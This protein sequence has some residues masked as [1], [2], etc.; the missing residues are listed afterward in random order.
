[1]IASE[2]SIPLL[3]PPDV[4]FSQ[5]GANVA[6]S[7]GSFQ[8]YFMH[9]QANTC[10]YIYFSSFFS[11]FTLWQLAFFTS[12]RWFPMST[13][14]IPPP[15]YCCAVVHC[16]DVP[17]ILKPVLY[18]L[19]F[20]N[21]SQSFV[22]TKDAAMN[23]HV[24]TRPVAHCIKQQNVLASPDFLNYFYYKVHLRLWKLKIRLEC[25]ILRGFKQL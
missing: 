24:C 20:S 17:N 1:M 3:S 2:V 14:T 21:C 6:A 8:T 18:W 22:P 15:F 23:N 4:W 7:C 19:D 13:D 12:W 11:F 25:L 10:V 5:G 16:I 9:I